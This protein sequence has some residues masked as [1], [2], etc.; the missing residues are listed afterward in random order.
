MLE[1]QLQ[2]DIRQYIREQG[3]Y[4][5]KYHSSQYTEKGIPDILACYKG[6]FIAIE[7]NRKGHKGEQTEYQKIHERNIYK[8]G[9]IY[10]LCDRIEEVKEL[11]SRFD[12]KEII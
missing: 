12:K 9:G 7:T 2:R 4:A 8:A 5:I 10:L 6:Y 3:G 1:S 11:L